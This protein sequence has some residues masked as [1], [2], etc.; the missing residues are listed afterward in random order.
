M[1]HLAADVA[2]A[3][4]I[5]K[6]D[7]LVFASYR[8]RFLSELL[9]GVVGVTVF[10]YVSRLVTNGV[11]AASDDYFSYAVIGLAVLQVLT[12]ALVVLP[13]VVRQEL[14]TGTFER[15]LVSPVGPVLGILA[16]AVFPFASA[17]LGA[18]VT[19][20]FGALVFG[21]PVVWSTAPL[22]LPAVLLGSAAFLPI[23]VLTT[24][25]VIVVKQ[26]GAGTGFVVTCMSLVGGVLFP[27][28]L[29]PDW[30][31]WASQAQPLTP[32][33][34]LTRHWVAGAPID[35]TWS[36]VWRLAL[37]TIVLLPPAVL[38][39]RWSLRSA[40]RRGTILEY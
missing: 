18:F 32:A 27:V 1:R 4:A 25:A 36:A 9:A 15:V 8:L 31:E 20:A 39:L 24:A 14:L 29:L 7:A 6:R 17:M 35:S 12:A 21:M 34:E 37:F 16:M 40:Q 19:V 30:I 13:M 10:Y 38:A 2:G 23:A 33:V 22:A 28:V 5:V 3:A 11:F 26:V